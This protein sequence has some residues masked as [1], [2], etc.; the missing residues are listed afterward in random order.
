MQCTNSRVYSTRL[1]TIGSEYIDICGMGKELWIMTAWLTDNHLLTWLT[2]S[3]TFCLPVWLPLS[4]LLPAS[5]MCCYAASY[6]CQSCEPVAGC[7]LHWTF[8]ICVCVFFSL[9]LSALSSLIPVTSITCLCFSSST[10]I[11][12]SVQG[13][14][15]HLCGELSCRLRL[16]TANDETEQ[17]GT[18]T[19]CL[20]F[21]F[22]CFFFSYGID[23]WCFPL[24]PFNSSQ[25]V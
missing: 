20:V 1:M 22:V 10:F 6:Y 9:A 5:P 12:Q 23:N 3:W 17:D 7:I 18:V 15:V 25:S 13:N 2:H 4:T 11:D 19:R 16:K 14:L 8:F 24:S 21:F